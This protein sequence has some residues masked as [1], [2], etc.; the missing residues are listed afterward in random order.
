MLQIT[1]SVLM[2]VASVCGTFRGRGLIQDALLFG[3]QTGN[4]TREDCIYRRDSND[5]CPGDDILFHYYTI[6]Y[7]ANGP[8]TVKQKI[9]FRSPAWLHSSGWEHSLPTVLIVHGYGGVS[10]DFLPAAV[11]RD[12]Y[13]SNGNYNVFLVDWGRLSAIPCYGAAVNN[14]RPVSKCIALMLSHL[15]N[16]GLNVD[17]LTC[18]G[19][20]LGAH[21]CG[22]IANYLPFRMHRI[23]GIDPAKPL[24][25]N[26]AAGRLD[27]GDAN[28]VQVIHATANYGDLSRMGHVDFC[29]N[30]G[31]IQPFC[32]NASNVEL[33]SHSRSVCYVAESL[34]QNLARKA[35]PCTK[36]CL[37]DGLNRP[38][39]NSL[40]QIP[41]VLLG[42][43]TPDRIK[44]VYCVVNTDAPYCSK[45][46]I[47]G[48][49]YCCPPIKNR[50]SNTFRC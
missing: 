17:Q 19:H 2:L 10:Q 16:A 27:P 21:V 9:E 46:N 32:S 45:T 36:R 41:Y 25:R 29:L 40:G 11:L 49:P 22:V 8:K 12:A 15:R 7:T 34:N 14:I 39:V 31:H 24:I 28:V 20:S 13:L 1:I 38:I 6:R 37:G 44:G 4:V 33:C 26:R 3:L 35:F 42:Q 43:H 30:G 5:S 23:I 50:G 47:N 48:S 18:V